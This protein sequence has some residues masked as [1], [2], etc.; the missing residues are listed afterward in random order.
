MYS[1][2]SELYASRR[3]R[4]N[5]PLPARNREDAQELPRREDFPCYP[6]R[7]VPRQM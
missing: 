4:C 7:V 3:S 2:Y 5:S 1:L 6:A